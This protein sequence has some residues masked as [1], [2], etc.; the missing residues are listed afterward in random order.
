MSDNMTDRVVLPF[1]VLTVPLDPGI[2]LIEASAGTGKTFNITRVVLRMLLCGTVDELSQILVVTFT[3]K[4]TQELVTRIRA[5]LREARAVWSDTPPPRTES[6]ADLFVLRDT[7]GTSG[8]AII[9]RAVRSLDDLGVS[10]IHSFCYRILAES[11]LET[12]VPFT[13]R[14]LEDETGP[15][16]RAAHD[17]ARRTLVTDA[18]AAQVVGARG[19]D[20]VDWVRQLVS[21]AR[22]RPGTRIE[23]GDTAEASLLAAFVRDVQQRFEREKARRQLMGYSDLLSI[24]QTVL[25][26]E[27][28]TG[29]L[30]TRI[31]TH[32]RAALIDEFQDTDPVQYASFRIAFT[33]CPLFLIGDPKQS[34]YSFR[35]ADI[36]TYLRV[37]AEARDRYTLLR[38]FRSSEGLVRAV[39]ATF[40][41]RG[42]RPFHLTEAEIALPRV[43]AAKHDQPVIPG[44]RQPME[45]IWID[46]SHATSRG[47]V[48]G[49]AA[50]SLG[51]TAVTQ[52]IVRLR[53]AGVAGRDIAVLVRRN[54]NASEMQRALDAAGVPSVIGATDDVLMSEEGKD[55][56]AL[57]R[58][59]VQPRNPRAVRAAM[60]TYIWGSHAAEI[61]FTASGDG[62]AE[63]THITAQFSDAQS[64][65]MQFGLASAL[66]RLLAARDAT[67]RLLAMPDGAR[68]VTNIRHLLEV[69]Q[70]AAAEEAIPPAAFDAWI[71]REHGVPNTPERRE[72]RLE[73]DSAAVQ[74]LTTFKAKG[75][76]WPVVFCLDLWQTKMPGKRTLDVDIATVVDAQG[77]VLD[78]GSPLVEMRKKAQREEELAESLRVAYVALTRAQSRCYVVAG[79]IL[80]TEG[81]ALGWLLPQGGAHGTEPLQALIAQ[82]PAIMSLRAVHEYGEGAQAAPLALTDETPVARAVEWSNGRFKTWRKSSY[83]ALTGKAHVARVRPPADIAADATADGGFDDA[84]GR[85]VEGEPTSGAP[86]TVADTDAANTNAVT[87][88]PVSDMLRGFRA[89]TAGT[90]AGNAL[91]SLFEHLDFT[92]A[93]TLTLET[94][95]DTLHAVGLRPKP[96]DRWTVAD[97]RA[98]VI[99]T[100]QAPIPGTNFSLAQVPMGATLREWRFTLPVGAFSPRA[101][102]DVLTQWGSPHAKAYAPLLRALPTDAFRGYLTG[103]IDLAFEHD[104]RWHIMDWKSNRLRRG[105]VESYAQAPMQDA[106]QHMHYTL[107]YHLYLLALHRH[108]RIRQ[109]GYDAAQHWGQVSYVFLRGVTG[110][111]DDGWFTDVP[112]ASLLHALDRV[113]GGAS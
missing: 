103:S 67:V 48:S 9:E 74:I 106:M 112:S 88:A 44:D 3:E 19:A 73:T 82:H 54:R 77:P 62:E 45:W 68:R 90:D 98:Q 72:M 79:V 81:S 5:T 27:G 53:A 36:R 46:A 70:S 105:M 50:L 26:R 87:N 2:T 104:G 49:S 111:G 61:A 40:R 39:D 65:W 99:A 86:G 11:A 108:L 57:A 69:F 4:A 76:E 16:Q 35:G 63:W 10:T 64:H 75:L 28:A 32:F 8:R 58:A 15:F 101:V 71:E 96:H 12:G 33:G 109:P 83:T 92:S 21:S 42:D 59:M 80:G 55:L 78:I 22:Q 18:E 20:P 37:A 17:W 1:D 56:I 14:F 34:I 47:K 60:A 52:E 95:R 51:I 31:R 91:H 29:P 13:A 24:V 93:D 94:V 43:E 85:D 6:N 41:F 107:Q 113:L 30:A 100:C 89:L 110:H 7:H 25:E 97:V 84:E 102:A 38:N 23:A 66:T